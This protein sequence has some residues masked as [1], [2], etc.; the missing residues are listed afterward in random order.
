MNLKKIKVFIYD[1]REYEQHKNA[2]ANH[3]I[4][5]I[6]YGNIFNDRSDVFVTAGNSYAMCDGG[7]D[8]TM[9]YFFD[10]IETRI[11][12]EVMKEWRGELP[13]GVS[14]VFQTPTN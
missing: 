6:H 14:I 1:Q 2:Y 3:P 4:L 9:N 7:I 11:Q 5:E 13:V 12:E 8:G 10:M